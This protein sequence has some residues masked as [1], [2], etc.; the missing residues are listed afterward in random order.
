MDT[1]ER[2]HIRLTRRQLEFI[3]RHYGNL[4]Q[5]VRSKIEREIGAEEARVIGDKV[6]GPRKETKT[7]PPQKATVWNFPEK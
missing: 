1:L 7:K 3:K 6:Q 2:V 5:W 4:S